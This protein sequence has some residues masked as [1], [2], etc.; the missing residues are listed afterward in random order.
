MAST[1]L[2]PYTY[3]LCPCS[4]PAN[5][6]RHNHNDPTTPLQPKPDPYDDDEAAFDPRA[7]RANFSLY[8]LEY[9]LYCVECHQI[10][11]PRCIAEEIVTYYCPNCLFEVPG[12]NIKS[13]GNRCAR[14]FFIP[15]RP[16]SP[17]GCMSTIE[18]LLC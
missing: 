17:F 18:D 5:V 9:L 3:I 14:Q 8:P 2:N 10:R 12:S 7:P 13:D 11:C 1:N 15:S 16:N 6:S 4:D